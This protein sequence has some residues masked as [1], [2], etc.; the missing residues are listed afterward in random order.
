MDSINRLTYVNGFRLDGKE[1]T[2][3]QV[4]DK[5]NEIKS[6][7]DKLKKNTVNFYEKQIEEIKES[8]I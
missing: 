7:H 4:V 1:L 6:A 2:H 3:S 8:Q 5:F